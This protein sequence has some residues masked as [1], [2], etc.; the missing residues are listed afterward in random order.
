[1]RDHINFIGICE[2]I[3][4]GRTNRD[5]IYK[6]VN[7]QI[8]YIDN[9]D[10]NISKIL[11][12]IY[13]NGDK[14]TDKELYENFLKV[15]SAIYQKE[16]SKQ[17]CLKCLVGDIINKILKKENTYYD[18]LE[19][20]EKIFLHFYGVDDIYGQKLDKRLSEIMHDFDIG[21]SLMIS[22]FDEDKAI[23][24]INK[25]Y[26]NGDMNNMLRSIYESLLQECLG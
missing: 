21:C 12:D 6:F 11:I 22:E 9:M 1:V 13:I 20:I 14:Q 15:L 3:V 7:E 25:M 26:D 5:T 17:L 23:Q 4:W 19:A 16:F 18:G 10:N 2:D 24:K 8:V